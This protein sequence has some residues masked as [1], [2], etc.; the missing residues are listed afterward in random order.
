VPDESQLCPSAPAC[1]QCGKMPV[2]ISEA[3][4][5]RTLSLKYL[6]GI[7]IISHQA[8]FQTLQEQTSH[9][10]WMELTSKYVRGV[11]T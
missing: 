4:N 11:T 1:W 9:L 3:K 2:A 7:R 5:T 8:T 6:V 10:K